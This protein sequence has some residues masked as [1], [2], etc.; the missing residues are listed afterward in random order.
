MCARALAPPVQVPSNLVLLRLG[1]R[2]WLGALVVVWGGVA[3]ACAF[4]AKPWHFYAL[5]FCLGCAESG[6]MPGMW[7][8]PCWYLSLGSMCL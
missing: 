1:A 2:L 4:L 3:A 5:R 7:C 6:T 8:V